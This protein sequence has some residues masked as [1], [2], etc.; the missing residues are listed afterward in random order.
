M[1]VE[2]SPTLAVKLGSLVVHADEASGH[3][4]HDFDMAAI[5]TLVDD[6]EVSEWIDDFDSALL[7]VKRGPLFRNPTGAG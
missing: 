6:Y 2:L 3:D 5:R 1:R 7:P 4:G